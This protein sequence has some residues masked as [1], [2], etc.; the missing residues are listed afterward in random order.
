MKTEIRTNNEFTNGLEI[1]IEL[2]RKRIIKIL[3]NKFESE[4]DKREY[5]EHS[6]GYVEGINDC[7]EELIKEIEKT[8]GKE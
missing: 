3:I 2:E 7:I 8:E 6:Q 5:C 4:A 1:G